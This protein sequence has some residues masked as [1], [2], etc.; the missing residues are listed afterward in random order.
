MNTKPRL[1]FSLFLLSLITLNKCFIIDPT[2]QFMLDESG[3]Y[4]IFHG[5]NVVVKLPPYIPDT[6]KFDPYTS[7]T[8]EDIAILKKLGINLVR[9]GIIWESLEK[10]EGNYDLE[11]LE[12]MYKIVDKLEQNDIAVIIDAHQDM[13]S[14]LFC[15]EGAPKFYV[16]KM[17]YQTDCSKNLL[18]KFFGLLTACI[19][20]SKNNWNYDESGLPVIE[21]CVAGSFIDYHKSPELMS[22]YDSFFDNEAGT[23]DAFVNFWKIVA[24]KFKNKKNVLGYD[25]WNEPWS[26]NLWTDLKSLMP[27]YIDNHRLKDFYTKLNDGIKEVDPNYTMLFQPIP[28]PDVLPLFGGQT[29]STFSSAPVDT[30]LRQQMFNVHN[31]CCAADQNICKDGEPKMEDATSRCASFHERKAKK[32]KQQAESMGVPVIVTE[33]GACSSSLACYYEMLGF[34]KAADKYLTSWCYWMY[35]AF[36]DH[37]TTA[38]ENEEGI[39]NPDGSLQNIKEKALSRTYIQSYQGI[40]LEINF[41]D[42]TNIFTASFTYNPEIKEPNVLYLYKDLKYPNGYNLELTGEDGTP[43]E[44]VDV[45]EKGNYVYFKIDQPSE[46]NVK[47]TVSPK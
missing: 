1:Y 32:N 11:H 12:K 7:F 19:P 23:L 4:K 20:L 35:K 2:K 30:E 38:A 28:F 27:G 45:E 13:F 15:G 22:I 3:R 34:L 9:L 39:F 17:T 47:V 36:N 40:P 16:D 46:L 21:D 41:D 29:L 42:D 26:P 43:I 33:F 10:E 25:L 8:D 6:E 24:E 14:R 31:Y 44:G 37:T 18:S 5:V